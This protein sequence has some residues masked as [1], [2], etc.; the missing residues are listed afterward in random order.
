L[1]TP[2]TFCAL[3]NVCSLVDQAIFGARRRRSV[4]AFELVRDRTNSINDPTDG[5]TFASELR[6][7][8]SFLGSDQF[9]RFVR[10][11]TGFT[12]HSRRFHWRV[13]A[14]KVMAPRVELSSGRVTYV[15]PE[16]RFFTGGA[17][18]VRGFGENQ[19]GPVVHVMGGG[20]DSTIRTSATGGTFL[21]VAN[22]EMR[23]PLRL[24]G[25]QLFGALFVDAGYIDNLRVTPGAGLRLPS[26]LGPIR[27]DLGFNP[28][29]ARSGPLFVQSGNSLLLTDPDFRPR[30]RLI[31]R[32][33]L[34]LSIGQAF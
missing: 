11:T 23:F 10:F 8:P 16:E 17:T 24:I 30:L 9:M 4:V 34:H 15:P 5:T 32:F 7:A 3:L 31:D 12:S 6:V 1:A 28:Y 13:R 21:A 33:Q 22:A 19:L 29:P 25:I 20:A 14:G 27:L 2:A 26:L 18:T